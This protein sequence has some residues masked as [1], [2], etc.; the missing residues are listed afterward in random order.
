MTDDNRSKKEWAAVVDELA[1]ITHKGTHNLAIDANHFPNTLA[2]PYWSS[3]P[4]AGYADYAWLV[5]F[6]YGYAD[7]D[8]KDDANPVRLVC[9]GQ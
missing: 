9:S 7:G 8:G 3:S 2:N 1:S 4:L 5:N 6:S